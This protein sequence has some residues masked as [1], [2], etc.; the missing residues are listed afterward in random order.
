MVEKSKKVL[1]KKDTKVKKI[2]DNKK[3]VKKEIKTEE[4]KKEKLILDEEFINKNV[5]FSLL[6]VIIIILVTGIVVSLSTGLIV[7]NNYDKI[8]KSKS[9]DTSSEIKEFTESYNHIINS[10]IDEVDKSKL[11]DAAI[12]GMYNFLN[13]EYSI[14]MDNDMTESLNEQLE[15]TYDGIGIEMTMNNKGVIYVT[16]V[17]KNTP[18]EKAGLKPDDIL[19]AL[20]GE[21][22]EGKTTAE[23]ASVIKKGTK[24]EF[25][26]TYKRDN[27]EK[28]VTVNKKHIY[29]N[30]VKSEI[31]DNIGYINISTFSATTE[32]QVKKELDNFDKNISNLIIDLRNNTGG[33]LNAA[34]DVSELFLKKGKVIYQLKDRNNKITKFTAKSGEYRH[35][36]NIIVIINGSTASASEILALA[37]KESANAKIVGTKS[38]GKGTVQETSKLKSGSMVKY[39]TAYWLSPEG[40]SINKT[41][42][43]PDY[44]IDGEEEQL[45]KAIEIAK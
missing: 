30:S 20:D 43:T 32:E 23:V 35:F 6:E 17:F 44:K 3:R 10:Y 11:I 45:K 36:N 8:S 40:N 29:I 4:P 27:I 5:N 9:D 16:Q 37:L 12:S 26:L 2:S 22:L 21:S 1:D 13:D 33:Y 31:F 34:Y 38:Y 18:A 24:S 15:G 19:V 41:G 7:Y 39:T 42:I 28:T 25:K 14:Y